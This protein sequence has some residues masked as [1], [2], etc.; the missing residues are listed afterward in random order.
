[1]IFTE[2]TQR[3]KMEIHVIR[4]DL[5]SEPLPDVLLTSNQH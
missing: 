1:M 3:H 5:T 4:T 2:N